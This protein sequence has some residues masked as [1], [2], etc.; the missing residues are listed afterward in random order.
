MV[1][2]QKRKWTSC[3]IQSGWLFRPPSTARFHELAASEQAR[4]GKW[5]GPIAR[6][7]LLH[8]LNLRA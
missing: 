7:K 8:S 2:K 4:K 1:G 5:L 3:S 6:K